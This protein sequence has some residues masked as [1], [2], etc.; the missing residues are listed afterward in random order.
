MS[1]VARGKALVAQLRARADVKDPE[2]L[3]AWLGKVK[4][5]RKGG[6]SA[7]RAMQVA[8]DP[9]ERQKSSALA[10]IAAEGGAEET[11]DERRQRKYEEAQVRAM[12]KQETTTLYRAIM[13]NGGIRTSDELREEYKN[14]PNTFIRKDGMAGDEM[15]DMLAS[16]YPELG[17]ES[18]SDLIDFF[19][20]RR[21]RAA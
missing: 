19:W 4:Q 8:S 12:E 2:A 9:K 10:D 15:A 18:E 1:K 6:L 11:Q 16:Y 5:L 17:I 7:R 3:A 13:E 20:E 14:I 21:T